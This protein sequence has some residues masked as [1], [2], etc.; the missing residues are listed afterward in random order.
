MAAP[1]LHCKPPDSVLQ[2]ALP[3]SQVTLQGGPLK[4]AGVTFLLRHWLGSLRLPTQS[5][6]WPR[7]LVWE[8]MLVVWGWG[9]VL[10]HVTRLLWLLPQPLAQWGDAVLQPMLEASSP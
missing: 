10:P 9:G 2:G 3:F 5:W 7:T 6:L 1:H 4:V 8:V